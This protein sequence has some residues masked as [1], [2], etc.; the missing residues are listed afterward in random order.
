MTYRKYPKGYHF[1]VIED[2]SIFSHYPLYAISHPYE[3]IF[4]VSFIT[5]QLCE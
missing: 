4:N 2:D 1:Y 3:A 5:K